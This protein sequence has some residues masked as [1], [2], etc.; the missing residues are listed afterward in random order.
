MNATCSVCAEPAG[1]GLSRCTA[2]PAALSCSL[3]AVQAWNL[4]HSLQPQKEPLPL[5]PGADIRAAVMGV[6][7]DL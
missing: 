6:C 5:T 2:S 7:S 4:Q 1:H 3:P